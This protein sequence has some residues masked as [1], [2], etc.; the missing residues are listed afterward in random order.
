MRCKLQKGGTWLKKTA[1]NELRNVFVRAGEILGIWWTSEILL[2]RK[3][4]DSTPSSITSIHL[5]SL[6][7]DML[8]SSE[9]VLLQLIER[10]DIPFTSIYTCIWYIIIRLVQSNWLCQIGC[11]YQSLKAYGLVTAHLANSHLA[12]RLNGNQLIGHGCII[13]E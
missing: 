4:P 5:L 11:W 10:Y 6:G 8:T 9:I 12:N 13:T 3:F 7:L 1:A 2:K